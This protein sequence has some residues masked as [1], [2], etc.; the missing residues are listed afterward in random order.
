MN[1]GVLILNKRE[2]EELV[3]H[4]N[5]EKLTIALENISEENRIFLNEDELESILDEI[6]GITDTDSINNTKEKISALLLSFR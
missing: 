4:V 5:L 3:L 1:R 2:L 6:G